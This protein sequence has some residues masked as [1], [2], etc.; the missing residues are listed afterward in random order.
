MTFQPLHGGL[1]NLPKNTT[2]GFKAETLF[3]THGA[4]GNP[5]TGKEGAHRLVEL[6]RTN[7]D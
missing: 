7:V 6:S 1:L 3:V 2:I 4:S 5:S